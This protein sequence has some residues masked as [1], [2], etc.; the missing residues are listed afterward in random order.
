MSL[1][2][3]S[4]Q[5]PTKVSAYENFL[6][7]D[8]SRD[9]IALDTGTEQHLIELDNAFC[10]W[11]GQIVRD[12]SADKRNADS[13]PVTH[14]RHAAPDAVA[15]S[16]IRG[17]GI[18]LN[19]EDGHLETAI[20]PA[21]AVVSSTTYNRKAIF[22][23]FGLPSYGY[24]GT[25]W[26][27]LQSNH[28]DTIRPA[29]MASVQRRLVVA[30]SQGFETRVFIS[31]V[32]NED[33]FPDDEPDNSENVL[34]AGYIDIAN[35]LGTADA[36]TGLASFEQDRLAI[37]TNDRTFIY[38]LDPNI[39]YWAV[40][41]R[42][43]INVGCTSH[44]SVVRAGSDLL[45]CSRDGVHS[46]KR[47]IENGI[48]LYSV[49]MSEKIDTLYRE[50]F[51]SVSNPQEISAVWNPDEN[52]YHIFFPQPGGTDAK[53]LTLTVNNM[54]EITEPAATKWSTGSF[55]NARCGD[56]LGGSLTYGTSGGVYTINNIEDAGEVAP[57]MTITTP[58][59]WHGSVN[60]MKDTYSL[61][62]QAAGSGD[63]TLIAYDE[64]NNALGS[65]IITV[66]ETPDDNNFPDVPLSTQYE[67]LFQYRYKGV[68]L[69]L[70]TTGNGLLRIIG[71]AVTVKTA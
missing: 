36:I 56:F 19:S 38:R 48:L 35:L 52:Q 55:L 63:I 71:F 42:A 49:T 47:S 2:T 11:R 8:T 65:T 39:E 34:R 28:L 64:L 41:D 25:A 30:G 23:A 10:D 40:D 51:R 31:R 18:A 57:Q 7:L 61:I 33:I 22:T 9:S 59:L 20:Y 24:D 4:A 3:S 1:I 70:T 5:V 29:F 13:F 67:W 54:V 62:L 69:R 6:G 37:F 16:E 46:I 17:D 43:N 21:N 32:D 14:I 68:K 66:S 12:P 44:N 50:L 15:W 60:T 53:R 45:F 26:T 27:R 58:I